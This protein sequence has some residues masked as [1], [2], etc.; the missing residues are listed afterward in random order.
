MGGR[1]KINQT[2]CR[3]ILA[4]ILAYLLIQIYYLSSYTV[5][6]ASMGFERELAYLFLVQSVFFAAC[7][8]AFFIFLFLQR[9]KK[10]RTSPFEAL[11]I[12][13]SEG[14][15]KREVPLQD[16]CSFLVTGAKSGKGVF[17]ETMHDPD[18]GRYVY[19]VC[20]LA[21]G[22]W[23]FEVLSPKRPV[24]LKGGTENVIYR[25]KEGMPYQLHATDVI[26]ADTCKIIM[27]CNSADELGLLPKQQKNTWREQNGPD[28]L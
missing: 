5:P 16:K 24:G 9:M 27:K 11:L 25:M 18:S 13:D 17:I 12:V 19:G 14:K 8:V 1:M 26:Y 15:V 28:S 7:I 23:Y 3:C 6:S 20:N 21:G 10:D 2:V 4:C 22:H